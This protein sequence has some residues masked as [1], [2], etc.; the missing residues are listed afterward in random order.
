MQTIKQG[1]AMVLIFFITTLIMFVGLGVLRSYA[2]SNETVQQQYHYWKRYYRYE[3]L[4]EYVLAYFYKHT[5]MQSTVLSYFYTNR[6]YSLDVT[7]SHDTYTHK[8]LSII[9]KEAKKIVATAQIVL[10]KNE[11]SWVVKQRTLM[12]QSPID[13]DKKALLPYTQLSRS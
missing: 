3:G 4:C 10:E 7:V 6:T 13:L 12:I 8:I 2:L 1:S 5:D 9:V 11:L